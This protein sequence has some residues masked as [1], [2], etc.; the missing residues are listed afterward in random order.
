MRRL[1]QIL[2]LVA[3]LVATG[4]HWDLVQSFAWA[5]MVAVY[6]EDLPLLEA[7]QET[8]NPQNLCEVCKVVRDAKERESGMANL[9]AK[10]EGKW[11]L[12]LP[13]L[14]PTGIAP[15]SGTRLLARDARLDP[16][17]ST[18]PATEPPRVA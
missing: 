18:E 7:V 1:H 11:L 3:W 8:F 2:V 12:L 14:T 10:P 16:Q 15:P 5:K 4:S 17:W 9:G 13:K 6:S